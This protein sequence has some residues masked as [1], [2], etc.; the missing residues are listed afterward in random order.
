M[1]RRIFLAIPLFAALHCGGEPVEATSAAS[2]SG[3]TSGGTDGTGASSGGSG[4]DTVG[5]LSNSASATTGSSGESSSAT[6]ADTSSSSG[7]GPGT[8][9]EGGSGD[10]GSTP[11]VDDAECDDLLPCNGVETCVDD[12]CAAGTP[13]VCSDGVD[14]TLD[15]CND[16]DGGTCVF[17]PDDTACSDGL[18]CNGAESCDAALGC[19][20]GVAIDCNDAIGC[21]DD[22]CDEDADACAFAADDAVCQDGTFCNGAETCDPVQGCIDGAPVDCNDLIACTTDACNEGAGQCDHDPVDAACDNG[23]FCDGAEAC[24]PGVGCTDGA[25]IVCP[26]DGVACTDD[27]CNENDDA[28][29]SVL[30]NDNC[31]A[32]QFCT[33][34]GCI[35]GS[36][37]SVDDGVLGNPACDDGLGCNGAEICADLPGPADQC[38]PGVA[39]ACG[40]PI[41]CTI[42][43]CV[44]PGVCEHAPVD[45]LCANGNPCDGEEVC[46]PMQG[47]IDGPDLDC[48]DGVACTVDVCVVNFGCNNISADENCDDGVFCNGAETCDLALGCQDAPPVVC[49]SDGIA[50][51]V[52]SCDE[53]ANTCT[54]VPDDDLCPC[55]QACNPGAGGCD[56]SC[57]P[58]TCDGHVYQC[59]NCLDD[60]ADC[61]VD[62]NDS[63]CFGP[64]SNNEDGLDGAIPGQDNAPC[65][66]DCYFDNNSGTGDDDC[67]WNH[68]CDPLEP[69]ATTCEYDPDANTPGTQASCAELEDMQSAECGAVCGPL[70]P[71]G[72]DCFGCCTVD[73]P[74]LG[75]TEIFLGSAVDGD[76]DATCTT[77]VFDAPN[78]LDLCH[79]CTQV[80]AC[81]NACDPCE[82][83]FGQ[84][85]L[86][87]ECGGVQDCPGSTPCGLP[88]QEPCPGGQF[89]LTGCCVQG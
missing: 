59:G 88:G 86:P 12:V 78:V 75:P 7:S 77:E 68:E 29:E 70:T 84:D 85:Q 13:I 53:Q 79:P 5:S 6:A 11:C 81:L 36:P 28:C 48:D 16:L 57:S 65:K 27:T 49:P 46:A 76:G 67:F 19:Q 71:N 64:C 56:D 55:G 43:S 42:D 89:C 40:D 3:D 41:G 61:D 14:C 44:E 17:A 87:P 24:S 69:S 60:D 39:I 66:H 50:C 74:G 73:L 37:C 23:V 38:Q 80:P 2:A 25:P 32:G 30:D 18:F 47:C 9:S 22:T 33:A 26:S 8:S 51:T 54:A 21:T 82:L 52:E 34:G 72:C 31:N 15:A 35:D 4:S 10:T 63:N 62:A 20:P 83:C 1:T 45:G 58:A